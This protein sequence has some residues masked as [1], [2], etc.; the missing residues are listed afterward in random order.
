MNN[1]SL[2]DFFSAFNSLRTRGTSSC[3]SAKMDRCGTSR[4]G[5]C[6]QQQDYS[7]RYDCRDED[8]RFDMPERGRSKKSGCG[9]DADFDCRHQEHVIP[10][11][12]CSCQPEPEPCMP[13]REMPRQRGSFTNIRNV[14]NGI[15]DGRG[16]DIYDGDGD[17]VYGMG[18]RGIIDTDGND[19][20]A[21]NYTVNTF[22]TI[23]NFIRKEVQPTVEPTTEPTIKPTVEPPDPTETSDPPEVNLLPLRNLLNLLDYAAGGNRD[24]VLDDNEL[25]KAMKNPNVADLDGNHKEVSAEE[26]AIF[27]K[28]KAFN[29]D[30]NLISAVIKGDYTNISDETMEELGALSDA[31]KELTKKQS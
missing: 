11:D 4:S 24:G 30:K 15:I 12:E 1:F 14:N 7:Q 6:C 5:G 10:Q 21:R 25:S 18:N 8:V 3:G 17:D 19:I 29:E 28:I 27:N 2:E 22:N 31:I 23:N 26:L 16:N 13:R 20:Y 9:K